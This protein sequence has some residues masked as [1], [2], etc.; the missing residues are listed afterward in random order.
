MTKQTPADAAGATSDAVAGEVRAEMARKRRTAADLAVVLGI[1]Q[2]TAGQR[3]NGRSSFTFVELALT[4]AW[5]E[6]SIGT[7]VA[8]AEKSV[9]DVAA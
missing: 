9:K 4:C 7:L 1:S 5:L 6:I 8:R 3:L 2:H